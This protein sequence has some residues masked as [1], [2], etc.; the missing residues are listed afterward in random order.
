MK[1]PNS[2]KR[3][4]EPEYGV[5]SRYTSFDR[6]LTD[7]KHLMEARLKRLNGLSRN[8]IITAK[9]LQL[10]LKMQ[11]YVSQ[12]AD[13]EHNFFTSFLT[14][15]IDTIYDKRS[16]FAKDIS[17][18]PVSLSQVLNNHREPNEQF[19]HRL[20]LHSELAYKD[21]CEFQK[22]IWYQVYY[23]EKICNTM[24][25]QKEWYPAEKNH[26][27]IDNAILR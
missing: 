25:E 7:G 13:E 4:I 27:N 3:I 24:A 17:I 8:Q 15:Y 14:S 26:V 18:T 1:N 9:L 23:H 16:M 2:A 6:K 20:M 10:K 5:D 12:P 22:K 19:M 11:E 21:V